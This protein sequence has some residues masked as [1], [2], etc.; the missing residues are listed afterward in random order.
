MRFDLHNSDYYTTSTDLEVENN[1]DGLVL[2]GR[3]RL[4]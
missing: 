3:L 2:P 1:K 4:L